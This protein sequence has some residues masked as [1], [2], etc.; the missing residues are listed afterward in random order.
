MSECSD[1]EQIWIMIWAF[2]FSVHFVIS[3]GIYAAAI[4]CYLKRKAQ[5]RRSIEE[6]V[7]KVALDEDNYNREEKK[8]EE[9]EEEEEKT[10]D[11]KEP[12]LT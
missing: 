6:S 2:V 10:V 9:V 12:S 4:N 3:E 8:I 1:V 5:Q 11:K 7:E